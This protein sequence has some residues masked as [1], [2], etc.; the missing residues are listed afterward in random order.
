[1]IV[2]YNR[3]LKNNIQRKKIAILGSTGHVAKSLIFVLGTKKQYELYLFARSL[4]KLMEFVSCIN[5]KSTFYLKAFD[6]FKQGKYD[7]IINCVGIGDPG[8]LISE[9]ASLFKLTETYDDI[10]LEYLSY[11]PNAI[12]IN[13]SSGAA[14]CMDFNSPANINS[15]CE[16]DINHI[17]SNDFYGIAKLNSEAKHRALS[18][19]N[20]IDVRI[21]SYFSRFI[22]LNAR[23]FI[24]EVISCIRDNKEFFT[25]PTN[26]FRDYVHMSDLASLIKKCM[27]KEQLNDVFDAYSVKPISKFELLDYFSHEYGL[28]YYIDEN[29]VL[30]TA[31][32]VKEFYFSNNKKVQEIG[33][34]PNYTSLD[35]IV[36]EVK[37]IFKSRI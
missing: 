28:R 6:E 22:N 21:F 14:Y 35:G 3:M 12:Y 31:T 19:F 36:E 9:R 23:Y 37:N 25:G 1:M 4:E 17:N 15:K 33:Y 26:I 8:K 32:G 20:I 2:G 16:L 13:F 24:N 18:D 10:I 34:F 11:N 7:V 5:I 29:M 30:K 27:H